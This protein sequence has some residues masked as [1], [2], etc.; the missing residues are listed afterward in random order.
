MIEAS[1]R[2]R[3][4]PEDI[5]TSCTIGLLDLLPPFYLLKFL[6]GA[7]SIS[8]NKLDLCENISIKSVIFWPNL[9]FGSPDIVITLD[10]N[11]I[12]ILEIKHGAGLHGVR[13][14]LAKYW[15]GIRSQYPADWKGKI[16]LIYLTH[17]P[18]IPIADLQDAEKHCSSGKFFWSNWFNLFIFTHEWL[19]KDWPCYSEKKILRSLH[20]Y[21]KTNGYTCFTGWQYQLTKIA[22]TFP[23]YH[24]L[25]E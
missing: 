5:F 7:V 10:D 25:G 12:L 8:K 17:H 3:T 15:D 14:Q 23:R 20:R 24:R 18:I 9:Q 19:Q 21:L 2:G 4:Q 1:M 11:T 16:F 22:V 6:N 13:N